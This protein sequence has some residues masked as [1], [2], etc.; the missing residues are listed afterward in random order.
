MVKR[1]TKIKWLVIFVLVL[2]TAFIYYG[3]FYNQKPQ[4][5][6][7]PNEI[8][9][10]TITFQIEDWWYHTTANLYLPKYSG[11]PPSLWADNISVSK[12]YKIR[13]TINP[14]CVLGS[15]EGENVNYYYCYN[16]T[17]SKSETPISKEGVL[18]KTKITNFEVDLVL[19]Q[20]ESFTTSIPGG[21]SVGIAKLKVISS[22]CRKIE[23]N[24]LNSFF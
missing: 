10:Q 19:N 11:M 22:N 17:Y 9:P 16:L 24:N 21:L 20:T 12:D 8:I 6:Q 15:K 4:N 13:G 23:G 14:V 1:K 3:N 5:I 2:I 18:G 7:C